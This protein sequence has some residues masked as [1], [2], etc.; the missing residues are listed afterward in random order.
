VESV[1]QCKDTKYQKKKSG[2]KPES[3]TLVKERKLFWMMMKTCPLL[4]KEKC[5]DFRIVKTCPLTDSCGGKPMLKLSQHFKY[6]LGSTCVHQP[7]VCCV[8]V[9]SVPQD[10]WPKIV[11]AL[12]ADTQMTFC[13]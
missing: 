11:C 3:E 10:K 7:Q 6:L 13:F 5:L 1:I 4:K 12:Q 8:N 2:E 9:Y